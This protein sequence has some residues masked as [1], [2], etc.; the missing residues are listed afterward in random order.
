MDGRSFYSLDD[1]IDINEKRLEQYNSG[2]QSVLGRFTNIILLYSP[3]T[4]FLIGLIQDII[5]VPKLN[6]LI[7]TSFTFFVVLF[8]ISIFFLIKLIMPVEIAYLVSPRKYYTDLRLE[9]EK[10]NGDNQEVDKL[11]KASYI[12]ELETAIATNERVFRRKSSFYYNA[13]TFV[14]LA[15]VPYL[16]CIGYHVINNKEQIQKVEIVNMKK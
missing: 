14:L 9:Y 7:A 2:Y 1:I 4:V 10:Q 8:S 15:A 11:I 3:I 5:F 16:I 6:W 13:L 12:D